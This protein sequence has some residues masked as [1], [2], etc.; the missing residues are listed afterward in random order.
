LLAD[1]L[2]ILNPHRVHAA[3]LIGHSMGGYIVALAA[4]RQAPRVLSAQE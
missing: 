1:S 2:T 4:V 3:R